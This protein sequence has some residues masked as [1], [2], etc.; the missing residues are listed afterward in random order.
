MRF[1]NIK[2]LSFFLLFGFFFL[3]SADVFAS[4]KITPLNRPTDTEMNTSANEALLLRFK[5]ERDQLA[6]N[7]ENLSYLTENRI[8][9]LNG[10]IDFLEK[11][12]NRK[13]GVKKA[14]A[15]KV[16]QPKLKTYAPMDFRRGYL[17]A[18]IP[19]IIHPKSALDP[20]KRMDPQQAIPPEKVEPQKSF[21]VDKRQSAQKMILEAQEAESKINAEKDP[22]L[23]SVS[24]FPA[25]QEKPEE[26]ASD[27]N[28]ESSPVPDDAAKAKN[29][30]LKTGADW[31]EMS[32]GD[33]EIYVLSVMGNL[34]KHDVYLMKPYSYY[35]QAIDAAVEKDPTLGGE[36]V[37]RILMQT[38]Y[39][40]EPDTRKDLQKVWK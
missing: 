22:V 39:A 28:E 34:S 17:L 29:K 12:I 3:Q 15:P 35:M 37:H 24:L 21:S 18:W 27:R 10:K 7:K 2:A 32:T 23:V 31:K 25:P 11:E 13:Q 9:I 40:D 30:N 36:Y 5:Q 26:K 16:S 33:K 8:K 20:E 4:R 14:A 19:N 1:P 38:A 6:Q